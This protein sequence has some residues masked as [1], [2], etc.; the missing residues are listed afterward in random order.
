MKHKID[1]NDKT[2]P[3][4]DLLEQVIDADVL[5]YC[6]NQKEI[7]KLMNIVL[8]VTAEYPVN[9]AEVIL[10]IYRLIKENKLIITKDLEIEVL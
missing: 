2:L 6:K 7:M 8:G 1:L 5:E 3:G 4:E 9:S 10:S